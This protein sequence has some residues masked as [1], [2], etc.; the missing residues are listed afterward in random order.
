MNHQFGMPSVRRFATV[1][2]ALVMALALTATLAAGHAEAGKKKRKAKPAK[3]TLTVATANQAQL[4]K[5]KKLVVKVRSTGKAAPKLSVTHAGKASYFKRANLRFRKKGV[6]TVR[7]ALT[8]AGRKQLAK[9][10]AKAVRVTAVYKKG[11]RKAKAVKGK[12]LAKWA[13]NS[14][15]SKPP[16]PP[17][18]PKRPTC[19]PLDPAVCMQPWPSNLYTKTDDSTQTGLRLDI[20]A[21]AMPKNQNGTPISPTDINRADGFSPGNLITVKIPSVETPAA[22]NNSNIVPA[23]DIGSYTDANAPVMVI[24]AETGQRQPIYAELDSNPTTKPTVELTPLQPPVVVTGGHPNDNPTNTADVNLIIRA[25]KNYTP[26][27]RY[28][29][30]LRNLKDASNNAVAAAAPFAACRD[31]EKITDAELLY[32]CNEIQDKVF[33]VLDSSGVAKDSSLYMAWDFT[34]ASNESTTGR[35]LKIR[36]DAFSRLGD[37]DLSDRKVTGTSPDVDVV[38]VCD[39][40]EGGSC[41]G[42][43]YPGLTDYNPANPATVP[44]PGSNEQRVVAGYIRD[45]PCYLNQDGC[46]TG[47][48]FSF[49]SNNNLTWNDTYTVDVPFLCT[50]P[51]S[52]VAGG[53]LHPG[54]TGIYGHGLLGQLNQVRSTGSTREIG[55]VQDSTWCGTNWDGFSE[56]DFATVAASL[57]D[58]SNF[59]KLADR[60]QQGFVNMMYLQR[61]MIH[62]SGMAA[63]PAFQVD[64]DGAGPENAGSVIDV[65]AG[66]NTRAM[67]HGISQGGIMGGAYTALAPDVDYGVLGVPGMNYSTLLPRSVDFDE[68]AHGIIGNT[69]LPNVG[70]YDNYPDQLQMPLVFSIMQLVWDR[71][72]ANG[73]ASSLNPANGPLPNTNAHSVLLGVADGDHQV[74]NIAAEVEARTIGAKRYA[75]TLLEGRH[76]DNEFFGIP[77]IDPPYTNQNTMVYYDGGPET[78][79]SPTTSKQGSKVAPLENVPPRPEWGY[80]GDPHSYPRVSADGISQAASF[81]LG[82]GVPTCADASEYCFSNGWDGTTGLP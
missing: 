5:A 68:Y 81:L 3:V 80:G 8:P 25:A 12:T 69:Y 45:V 33:P 41:G 10:G 28:V 50:I 42:S 52:V 66:Q 72:E 73:Y 63:D 27:H 13:G 48:S 49:D 40:D 53:T 62:P 57:K 16:E 24:D 18:E 59:S 82:D 60:M 32:R 51:K 75:P 38:A 76:W 35:A 21:E 65:T 31:N 44:T 22:F 4:I 64:P 71:G 70:L 39:A 23:D 11:K 7:I 67:Y 54:A 26:G 20:P 30:V 58:L 9:C 47:A 78:F 6:K 46:P 14:A 74:A 56:G 19:D 2:F 61:A 1:A 15:C 17:V 36:D 55:N 77:A 79:T 34:V 37:T 43:N 29:V